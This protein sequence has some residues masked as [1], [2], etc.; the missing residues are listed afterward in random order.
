MSDCKHTDYRVLSEFGRI[1][2][3]EFLTAWCNDCGAFGYRQKDEGNIIT[4]TWVMPRSVTV[5]QT[6]VFAGPEATVEVVGVDEW[7]GRQ[8]NP[9]A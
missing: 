1:P 8:E 6:R 2:G 4:W 7:V 3:G 5:T 9:H